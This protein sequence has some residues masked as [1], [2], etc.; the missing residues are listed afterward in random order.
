M[1]MTLSLAILW[2][3]GIA[4]FAM[5]ILAQKSFFSAD[6]RATMHATVRSAAETMAQE[7]SQAGLVDVPLNSSGLSTV[8]LSAAV[9]A[10]T[11]TV[12]VNSISS[13]FVNEWVTAGGLTSTDIPELVQI[14]AISTTNGT[15]TATFANAHPSGSYINVAGVFL[16]GIMSQSTASQLVL[17]GDI[18]GDGSLVQVEYNWTTTG[19]TSV[20]PGS[21]T[22]GTLTRSVTPITPSTTGT[23]AITSYT[24]VDNVIANPGGASAFQYSTSNSYNTGV[25]FTITVQTEYPDRQTGVCPTLTKSFLNLTARNVL[26]ALNFST[27]ESSFPNLAH[28]LQPI[29][30]VLASGPVN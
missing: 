30:S 23:V 2:I 10:G 20:C 16:N 24:L 7:I 11:A 21:T 6:E 19:Q 26:S 29:P 18:L 8:T 1:E 27:N 14:T 3:I 15:I 17:I 28:Q 22:V 5:L 13:L 12:A 9:S 4:A 25:A